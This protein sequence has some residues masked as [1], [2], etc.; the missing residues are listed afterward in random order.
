MGPGLPRAG[1]RPRRVLPP[2]VRRSRRSPGC[3]TPAVAKTLPK[4]RTCDQMRLTGNLDGGM[5]GFDAE[6]GS[7]LKGKG[8]PWPV[9]LA[10]GIAVLAVL[11]PLG[12][13][14]AEAQPAQ[15]PRGVHGTV[16]RVR[17]RPG[18]PVLALHVRQGRRRPA[19]PQRPERST[20]RSGALFT[21]PKEFPRQ[22]HRRLRAH[23]ALKAAKGVNDFSPPA[24][25]EYKTA[26]D[27][28]G[29]GAGRSGPTPSTP[30]PRAPKRVDTKL[31]EQKITPGRRDLEHHQRQQSRPRCVALR[32]V[33]PL[34]RCRTS[35]KLK[36]R[37][38]A[39]GVLGWQ[40]HRQ[41]GQS[42]DME[43]LAGP[44]H[45]HP[46]GAGSADKAPA[47]FKGTFNKF[48][49]TSTASLQAWG[50][51]AFRKMNKES[52]KDD[53]GRSVRPGAVAQRQHHRDPQDRQGPAERRVELALTPVLPPGSTG[54]SIQADPPA[55][56]PMP[57]PP[58]DMT[59]YGPLLAA[60]VGVLQ[61][62]MKDDA[63]GADA[64]GAR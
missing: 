53:L 23:K 38:G 5:G 22:G 56:R 48:A 62:R 42:I 7:R 15:A 43:F 61:L 19:L 59:H 8:L 10:I 2:T 64:G 6:P 34:R 3:G 31:R 16:R 12:A 28:Y 36:G 14:G 1:D 4:R 63:G 44:R 26:L 27:D 49:A 41:E 17:K 52:K 60:G 55:P 46:G 9:Y 40:V 32:Q 35:T 11:Q 45:L 25:E 51:A 21:D 13:R 54:C 18:Q 29:K 39:L 30:G 20:P 50:K 57:R 33:P 37:P 24:P 58:N 47:T